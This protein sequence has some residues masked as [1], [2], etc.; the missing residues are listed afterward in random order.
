V[1]PET[2]NAA[3]AG[4]VL[5]L[6]CSAVVLFLA[7]SAWIAAYPPVPRDLGGAPD[8][9]R[10]AHQVRIAVANDSLDAWYLAGQEPAIVIVFHGYGRDHA[11]A[12]RYARFL[13]AA[14]YGVLAPDFR[15][16]RARDRKPTTLGCNEIADAEAALAWVERGEATRGARVALLGESLGGSMALVLAARHP[17]VAA[18]VADCPFA[19]GRRAIED[20]M[21]RWAHLPR[22]LTGTVC[23]VGRTFAGC[24]PCALDVTQAA[25]SLRTRPLFLIHATRDNRFSTDQARDIWRSA[26]AKDE[27]WLLDT[28]HNEAWISHRE[29]YEQRVVAFLDRALEEGVHETGGASAQGS[30]R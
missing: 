25:E 28:G 9:D 1:S 14:G 24:D 20:S 22:A 29:E 7:G 13:Q 4:R 2:S 21:E 8:L 16:S 10:A 23:W 15:S 5:L 6:A 3:R 26:G 19:S 12:W 27:L 11:R 17:E 30:E 18:V